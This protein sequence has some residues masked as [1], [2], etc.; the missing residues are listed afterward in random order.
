MRRSARVKGSASSAAGVLGGNGGSLADW[1]M[2]SAEPSKG[3]GVHSATVAADLGPLT[4][5]EEILS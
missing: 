5:F 3:S 4:T 1:G 2:T